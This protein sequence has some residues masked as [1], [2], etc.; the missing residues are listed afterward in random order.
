MGCVAQHS[1]REALIGALRRTLE[2][3]ASSQSS[4]WSPD[5][6]KEIIQQLEAA[7]AA[8]RSGVPVDRARLGFLFAPTGPI[9]ETSIDNGWADEFLTL[10][11]AVDELLAKPDRG[12]P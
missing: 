4:S 1:R 2:L 9:Q 3:I 6:V 10:S 11:Q 12:S 5:D 7:I 8:L